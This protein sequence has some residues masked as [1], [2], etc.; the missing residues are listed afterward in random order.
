MK[1]TAALIAEILGGSVDGN[2]EAEV[3]NLAK[4]EEA[5]E[6]DLSF[7]ANPK[8]EKW[9]TRTKASVLVV[10]E[11]LYPESSLSATLVRV[12]DP[13]SGFGKLMSHFHN[14]KPRKSG[15][16]P[17]AWVHPT[18]TVGENCFIGPNAVIG[19]GASIGDNCQVFG[20]ANV[21]DRSQVGNDTVI[22][23]GAIIYPDCV[24]GN[25][26]IIHSSAVVGSDGFGFAEQAD[27]RYEKIPQIGNVI[28]ED[29]VEIG[30]NTSIDRATMGSTIIRNGV[31]LDNL[32]HIGHNCEIGENT[33]IV[34]MTG[35]SGSTK[36]GKRCQ[37]GGQVGFIGHLQ[38]A[39]DVKIVAQSAVVKNITV[40][41][42]VWMGSPAI[43]Y[44]DCFRSIA[45]YK[46]LPEL[47]FK[48][49]KLE[50]KLEEL[51]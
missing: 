50:D 2:P 9:A 3:S 20:A 7:I 22:F 5:K 1:I 51:S 15:V 28:I 45:V 26:C 14:A 11:Q 21:G 12:A 32:V 29:S 19:E 42:T 27:G 35:V 8:Y 24:V 31:K 37:I 18:A 4:I 23:G 36:I 46:R 13:Y 41:G 33:A 16:H 43:P 34:A 44:K 10:S 6:G 47:D 49:K 38:I 17:R 30:A 40:P 48:L 25:N 39:D